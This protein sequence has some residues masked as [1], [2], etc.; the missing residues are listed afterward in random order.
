MGKKI[1]IIGA[2]PAGLTAAWEAEKN[3]IKTTILESDK[4]VGGI[5]RTVNIDGWRFD[6]GGHRF[7]TKVNEVNDLWNEILDEEDFLLR[8]RLSRIYYNKKFFNYP[9]KPLNAL[10]NL[11]ILEAFLCI[12]SYLKV[13]ISPPKNQNSFEGWVAARF[14]WRLYNIFFKTYTEKVWGIKASEIGSD[15]AS[16]RIKNLSLM[17]AIL[18]SFKLNSSKENVT[19]LID[20]F[21]YPKYGPGMM[22]EQA[23]EKLISKGHKIYFNSK[24]TEIKKMNNAYVV[25]TDDNSEFTATHIISSL[26]LAHLPKIISDAKNSEIVEAGKNLKFRDFLTVAIVVDLQDSFPDNWIY[27]HDPDVKVGRIQNYGNWSP[28]LVKDN[29]TCLGMEYFVNRGDELWEMDNNDLIDF[30]KK[31]LISLGILEKKSLLQG[32]VFRMPKA[33]PVYDLEYSENVDTIS[34]W[35]LNNHPDVYPVGRNGMHRYNNQDHSMVTAYLSIRNI[36][37]EKNDIWNVNVED[38]YHEEKISE[39]IIPRKIV[40]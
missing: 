20:E 39:R 40:D 32:Y 4:V 7:F 16:Q 36:L 8:P 21:K 34:N 2:G 35:I 25:I 3:G 23:S 30:A 18:N 29:K 38:E 11:G 10:K 15:W 24:V 6:I 27:I 13:K 19:T 12:F 28:Y 31:E 14:G 33:Y 22:W 17:K 9:L 5:S 37:G 26:P 1:L